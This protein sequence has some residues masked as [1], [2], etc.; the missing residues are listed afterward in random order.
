MIKIEEDNIIHYCNT[1]SLENWLSSEE[2]DSFY[3]QLSEQEI[4]ENNNTLN[5][6]LIDLEKEFQ[7]VEIEAKAVEENSDYKS[8]VFK[9]KDSDNIELIAVFSIKNFLLESWLSWI[10]LGLSILKPSTS[11]IPASKIAKVL[12]DNF[13]RFK[14]PEDNDA[15]EVIQ[16]ILKI[17]AKNKS[18]K[19]GGNPTSSQIKSILHHLSESQFENS[20]KKLVES[21]AIEVSSWGDQAPNLNHPENQWSIKI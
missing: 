3:D 20:I 6:L 4:E 14:K 5:N 10:G 17:K 19:K 16:T 15:I 12:W 9:M 21:H 2:L 1:S 13:K 8:I 11:V 18:N 7:D